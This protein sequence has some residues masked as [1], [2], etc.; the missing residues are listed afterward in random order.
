MILGRG[1]RFLREV[2]LLE[3]WTSTSLFRLWKVWF[4][5]FLIGNRDKIHRCVLGMDHHC[6]WIN[7]CVGSHNHRHFFLFVANLTLAAATIIIAGFP[8]FYDH[9]FMVTE[10][11]EQIWN[12]SE[13]PGILTNHILHNDTRARSTPRRY[14]RLW[15]WVSSSILLNR[16]IN[17]CK[18]AIV[19]EIKPMAWKRKFERRN[20]WMC[21]KECV[22]MQKKQF[23]KK[24]VNFQGLQGRPSFFATCLVGSFCWWLEDSLC[25]MCTL[26]QLDVPT[27]TIW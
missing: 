25:G 5:I 3:K 17:T 27:L 23:L 7:Q 16:R 20:T 8:S 14:L 18:R 6:I 11:F 1:R 19:Y 15:R 12:T 13:L 26:F 4:R 24:G 22:S 21:T 9:I 2:Q 10:H